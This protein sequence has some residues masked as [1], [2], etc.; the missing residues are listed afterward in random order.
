MRPIDPTYAIIIGASSFPDSDWEDSNAFRESATAM[1]DYLLRY[2][3]MNIPQENM[4]DLFDSTKSVSDINKEIKKFLTR[5]KDLSIKNIIIYY[6]GHGS[7]TTIDQRYCLA[8]RST[9]QENLS[10]SAYKIIDLGQNLR[11]SAGDAR[12][13]VIIDACFA[14]AAVEG[15]ITQGAHVSKIDI[16]TFDALPSYGTT[17]LCAANANTMAIS[18]KSSKY[19][20]FSGGLIEVLNRGVSG[21]PPFLSFADLHPH[22]VRQIRN[23]YPDR[24]VRPEVH[25]SGRSDGDMASFR[26]FP[27]L[28]TF[29]SNQKEHTAPFEKDFIA[30]VDTNISDESGSPR[31]YLF[32]K[33]NFVYIISGIM[34]LILIFEFY[35]RQ[36]TPDQSTSTDAQRNVD[37]LKKP[38]D[39]LLAKQAVDDSAWAEAQKDGTQVAYQAY[40]DRFPTG[41]HLAAARQSLGD[42]KRQADDLLEQQAA[43]DAAWA[44]ALKDNTQLSYQAYLDHFPTGAHASFAHQNLALKKQTADLVA[45]KTADD[46]AWAEA[47]KDGTQTAYQAYIDRFP[48]G[49]HLAAARQSLGDLK[50][51]AD[52]LLEQQAAD[53]AAWAAALKDNTQLSYQAYIDS[54]PT[55]AHLSSARRG[56]KGLKKRLVK[57][58]RLTTSNKK[59]DQRPLKLDDFGCEAGKLFKTKNAPNC[60]NLQ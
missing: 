4:L 23:K 48:T 43:D 7:F 14:G 56:L 32:K 19:T 5:I 22:T 26:I 59:A 33:W 40:I 3:G 55:G 27:N 20:M 10:V 35:P 38:T 24:A 2:E 45:Q 31:T 49:T 16:D 9:D 18:E 58:N 60:G 37:I 28:Y 13:F 39:D 12:F 11:R 53:D 50:R 44:A 51:Q 46:S 8:L 52:D 54:F 42:L 57:I 30:G 25:A 34:L 6:T 17:L 21:G 1:K 41:T 36:I 29:Q 47:Q 15:F